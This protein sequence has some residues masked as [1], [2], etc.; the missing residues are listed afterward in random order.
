MKKTSPIKEQVKPVDNSQEQDHKL[1]SLKYIASNSRCQTNQSELIR[2]ADRF[3]ENIYLDQKASINGYS[4]HCIYKNL[5]CDMRK[6][7]ITQFKDWKQ[8]NNCKFLFKNV[9]LKDKFFP[10]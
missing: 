9:N 1:Q 7:L 8:A 4:Y 5:L 6:N 3:R 10:L 2:I